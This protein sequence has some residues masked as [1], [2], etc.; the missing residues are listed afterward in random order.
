M[1]AKRV[2]VVCGCT[3]ARAC[4]GGCFWI[5][6]WGSGRGLCTACCDAGE[7]PPE[8]KDI[9]GRLQEAAHADLPRP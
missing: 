7:V 3:E 8:M 2:C 6:L 4:P 5:L 9:L 1:G